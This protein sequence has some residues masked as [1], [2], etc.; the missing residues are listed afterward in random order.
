[1]NVLS[2][3]GEKPSGNSCKQLDFQFGFALKD[4]LE[5][6]ECPRSMAETMGGNKGGNCW[7]GAGPRRIQANF[8]GASE[9]AVAAV[10]PHYLPFVRSLGSRALETTSQK[11]GFSASVEPASNEL[12]ICVAGKTI[13]VPATLWERYLGRY[14]QTI[15]DTDL[16]L[17]RECGPLR[18]Y[19]VL[20]QTYSSCICETDHADASVVAART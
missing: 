2:Q 11:K 3:R 12:S 16:S 15:G 6:R 5:Y 1:M 7:S 13:A 19:L 8:P 14:L 4:M 20:I 10:R 18:S 9:A 17:Y